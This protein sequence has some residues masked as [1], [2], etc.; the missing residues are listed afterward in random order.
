M[1][2]QSALLIRSN[3]Y[4]LVR[5]VVSFLEIFKGSDQTEMV[6]ARMLDTGGVQEIGPSDSKVLLEPKRRGFR[7]PGKER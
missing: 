2:F 1:H 6:F 5:N 3:E 7:V 4:E